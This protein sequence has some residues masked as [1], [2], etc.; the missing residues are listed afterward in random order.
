MPNRPSNI[1]LNGCRAHA[2]GGRHYC[3]Q[4]AARIDD[5]REQRQ[6][7]WEAGRTVREGTAHKRGYDARWQRVSKMVRKNEPA[8]RMCMDAL[9]TLVDHIVPLKQGGERLA[10]DNLQ[11]LCAKCHAVKTRADRVKY[12]QPHTGKDDAHV[13][14]DFF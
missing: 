8:C 13:R 4:C 11:P 9:A 12:S 5:E 7:E 14:I 10:M 2:V 6:A 3:P 1:C